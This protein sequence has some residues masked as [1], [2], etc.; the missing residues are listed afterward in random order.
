MNS[1]Y[2]DPHH[3]S[4]SNVTAR[5][6]KS[7]ALLDFIVLNTSNEIEMLS[8][9]GKWLD[10]DNISQSLNKGKSGSIYPSDVKDNSMH[11]TVSSH[12]KK[13]SYSTAINHDGEFTH[14]VFTT[15]QI[16]PDLKAIKEYRDILAEAHRNGSVLPPKPYDVEEVL[17]A[18]DGDIHSKL[19]KLL[20]KNYPVPVMEEWIPYIYDEF[21]KADLIREMNIYSFNVEKDIKGIRFR[22]NEYDIKRVISEG[23]AKIKLIFADYEQMEDD[24]ENKLNLVHSTSDYI[25]LFANE[26]ATVVQNNLEVRFDPNKM[27]H[28]NGFKAMNLYANKQGITGYYPPQANAIMGASKTLNNEDFVFI[29]GEMGSGKSAIGTAIPYINSFITNGSDEKVKPFRS[30][31]ISPNIMVNKWCREIKSRVPNAVVRIIS[32]HSDVLDLYNEVTYKTSK[33]KTKFRLPTEIEYYVMSSEVMKASFLEDPDFVIAST[34]GDINKTEDSSMLRGMSVDKDTDGLSNQKLKVLDVDGGV[35]CPNCRQPL[36]DKDDRVSETFFRKFNPKKEEFKNKK[37]VRN[38]MCSENILAK[39]APKHMIRKWAYD[40]INGAKKPVEHSVPCGHHFWG[41]K[42]GLSEGQRKISPAWLINKKFPRGF[43]KYLIADEVHELASGQAARA[44]GFGQLVNHT[45]KQILLT[46]TLFG[47]MAKDIFYLLARLAPKKLATEEIT[48]TDP[49]AFNKIYGVNETTITLNTEGEQ[50]KKTTNQKPGINPH[51]FPIYLMNNAVF[52]E[53]SDLADALPKYEEIPVAVRMDTEHRRAYRQFETNF[54]NYVKDH[55]ELS[56]IRSLSSYINIASQYADAPF[57][58]NEVK[59]FDEFGIS[60]TFTPP[61]VFDEDFEPNKF[62]ELVSRLDEEIANGR[63]NL[64]Y[65]KYTGKDSRTQMNTWLYEKLKGLG[66]NVGILMNGKTYDGIKMPKSSIDR[67]QWLKDMMAK[68]NWDILITNPKL[69]KVGLDLLDYPTIHFYQLDYST[70]DYMQASRRSW[71]IGQQQD[72][73]VYTY[74]NKDTIQENILSHLAR[75][76]DASLAIQGKFSEEGLRAM[77]EASGSL[78]DI[79]KELINGNGL[80]E[81]ETVYATFK[82]KNKSFADMQSKEFEEYTNYI[83]NPIEGGIE[84]VRAN[85]A[86][87]HE[88]VD[89]VIKDVKKKAPKTTAVKKQIAAVEKEMKEEV[90]IFYDFIEE[91]MFMETNVKEKNFGIPKAKQIVE[92]QFSLDLFA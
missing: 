49:G 4:V 23:I 59:I 67:E 85:R 80:G 92:G 66:Y 86:K 18:L 3:I 83:M 41:P 50:L 60:H 55:K 40:P 36:L 6:E 12:Q 39:H 32:S 13:K 79:A 81:V 91:A 72:V 7:Q 19:Y 56:G 48:F 90:N 2:E 14:A 37:T 88:A 42:V 35:F 15:K 71:R 10:I 64:V 54:V 61:Q 89:E 82:R 44:T 22:G 52:L 21:L 62:K 8:V 73:K 78:T 58:F 34:L 53:L 20:K 9:V 51:L 25:R 24:E 65:A 87:A 70:F 1:F 68:H 46:G 57:N 47:G 29:V 31:V 75:K 33:G 5:K 84:T 17:I 28:S 27:L 30:I 74:I 76:I 43:F 26:L 38:T 69:V 63:K 77:S 11:L 45:T 16:T